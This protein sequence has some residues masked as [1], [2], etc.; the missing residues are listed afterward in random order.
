MDANA[1]DRLP[2]D[3][4]G[5]G[6]LIRLKNWAVTP[7]GA[8]EKWPQSLRTTVDLVLAHGFPMV[9]LWGEDLIQIYN[10]GYREVMGGKHPAGL[11]QP[12]HQCWPEVWHI[13]KPIYERVRRG[14]T[15][16]FEDKLFPIMRHGALEDAWFTLTYSPLRDEWGAIVGVL[17]TVVETTA[18]VKAEEA[19][20]ASER[21][22]HEQSERN[23]RHSETE[24]ER[25]RRLYEAIL[26]NTP[27]F[28]YVFDLDHRFIYANEVLLRMWGR[29]WDEAV[30]KTC[31]ELGY[32]DWHAGMHDREIEQVVATKQP[33]R[34]EVPFTGAFGR[35]IYDYIFVPV[36]DAEGHVEAVA[37][38]TRDVTESRQAE[39][40]LR[41]SEARF[42]LTADAVPQIVWI[43]D[44]EGRVE[45]FNRQWSD[46]TGVPYEPTTAA[47]V[48]GGFV[49]PED[50]ALTMERFEEAQRTGG[51][52][53]VEHRIRSRDGD[54][55][56]FLVRGEPYRDP[57]S[58]EITRWFG[59]SVDIHDRKQAEEA[60]RES[61]ERLEAVAT[62]AAMGVAQMDLEGR[63]LLVNDRACEILGRA[64]K[65]VLSGA[66]RMLDVT[67][68]DDRPE[69]VRLLRRMLETG[70]PF[71][72][73]K[74]YVR[75]DGSVIW[76]NNHVSL[77][78]D[79]TGKP[80]YVTALVQDVTE[81]RQ[82]EAALRASEARW[83]G[84]FEQMQEG[85]QVHEMVY[86]ADG[87]AVDIRY[88]EI[89]AAWARQTGLPREAVVGRRVSEILPAE[90][91]AFWVGIF[92]RV[93]E[94]GEAAHIERYMAPLERWFEVIAYPFE[95]GRTASLV[96]DVTARKAEEER[97]ALL[98]REVDHRA[99]NA[100]A[101][102]EAALR[103]TQA[104]DVPSF[105]QI[106]LGRVSALARAQTLLAQDRWRGADL[107]ALAEGELAPFVG[108]GGP[109]AELD[110]VSVVLPPGAAQPVA[111]ALH[112]LATNA[113]KYGALSTPAGRVSVSWRLEGGPKGVLRLRWAEA[114]GPPVGG[115]PARRGFGSRVLDAT[116]RRQLGGGVALQ[117]ERTGLVCDMEVPLGRAL[118]LAE[119]EGTGPF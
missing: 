48:A 74:R 1:W 60:L 22:L 113:V 53:R 78:R 58:G 61:R 59:A 119:A 65:E 38:T 68:P 12:T 43:T 98:M 104:P 80:R 95:P 102:V 70:E 81:R 67:H 29:T 44:P 32:P 110:G 77:T 23:L 49:H 106:A 25:Q 87:R 7:L 30:G 14:E 112:E 36:L 101:V 20:Q 21:R 51:T 27:D 16:T 109:R 64:R 57:R 45:F 33:I 52:F 42:R 66:E 107:R 47:E 6:A 3:Q 41:E 82:A 37:G 86:D 72:I 46:Y 2:V 71:S 31:L 115:P 50:A 40:A 39:E 13:N 75:P 99:K 62:H 35:R 94:T 9:A 11:G 97:Q 15:L 90:E 100:L 118:A 89:N 17:V 92:A 76:V 24:R 114:G 4:E 83:R 26:T 5:M 91:V 73:A 117:W 108:Q 63:F 103:L 69:N 34:G 93:A 85:V 10:D 84:L 79:A 8:V 56:W 116:L 111:M 19:H 96:L 105:Q 55:R 18:K 88:L 54:Y 28:A